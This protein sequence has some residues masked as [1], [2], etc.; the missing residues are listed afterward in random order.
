MSDNIRFGQSI[1]E[2]LN[3][4]GI[5]TITTQGYFDGLQSV[6][7]QHREDIQTSYSTLLTD[8][9]K[10]L[11]LLKGDTPELIIKITKDRTGTPTVIQKTWLVSKKKLK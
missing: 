4:K 8:V 2:S 7:V 10:C 1:T 6:K 11:D 9:I 3:E 5:T